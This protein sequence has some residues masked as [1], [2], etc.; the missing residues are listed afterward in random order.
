[1]LKVQKKKKEY[2]LNAE[3]ILDCFLS[4]VL[5]RLWDIY[6]KNSFSDKQRVPRDCISEKSFSHKFF[7][8]SCGREVFL[9]ILL[10][11]NTDD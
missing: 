7:I 2:G 1:M 9:V 11:T 6:R 3:F 8:H 5:A 10:T 4:G